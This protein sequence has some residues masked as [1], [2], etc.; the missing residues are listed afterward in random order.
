ME[1]QTATHLKEYQEITCGLTEEDR[2]V[3]WDPLRPLKRKPDFVQELTEQYF[4]S[5]CSFLSLF[6]S[7]IS[8]QSYSKIWTEIFKAVDAWEQTEQNTNLSFSSG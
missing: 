6:Y 7:C 3:M 8:L 1:P 2:E 5:A 4:V